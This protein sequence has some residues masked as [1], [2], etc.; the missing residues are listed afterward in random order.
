[1]APK[2]QIIPRVELSFIVT[3]KLVF[4]NTFNDKKGN[5]ASS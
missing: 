4:N 1:M 2:E 5:D 3:L